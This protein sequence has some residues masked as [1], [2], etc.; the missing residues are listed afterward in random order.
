MLRVMNASSAEASVGLFRLTV[1]REPGPYNSENDA[2]LTVS[3]DVNADVWIDELSAAVKR[4]AFRTVTRV[5]AVDLEARRQYLAVLTRTV[6][7]LYATTGIGRTIGG[8]VLT[9][10]ISSSDGR[11]SRVEPSEHGGMIISGLGQPI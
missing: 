2:A 5:P 8:P 10:G 7:D 6:S 9:L 3:G 4:A 11:V 1:L